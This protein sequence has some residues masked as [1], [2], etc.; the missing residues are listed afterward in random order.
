M[1]KHIKMIKLE[2]FFLYNRICNTSSISNNLNQEHTEYYRMMIIA[3][4]VI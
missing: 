2:I 4:A 3:W 1:I